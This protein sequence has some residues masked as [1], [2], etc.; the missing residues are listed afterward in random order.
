M[1][2]LTNFEYHG[3]KAKI[4]GLCFDERDR[5]FIF[6]T[7]CSNCRGKVIFTREEAA[8]FA[9]KYHQEQNKLRTKVLQHFL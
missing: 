4:G 7:Y 5:M 3:K 1:Q 8:Y 9:A 6:V 2:T